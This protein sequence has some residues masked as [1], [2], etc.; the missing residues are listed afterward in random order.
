MLRAGLDVDDRQLALVAA[1]HSG[2]A[3]HVEIARSILQRAGL[4]ESDLG[5]VPA[6]PLD[7]LA[8]A[9]LL[10]GGGHADRVH[11]NCSGKHAG[12][13]ATC[14]VRGWSTDGYLEPS[15]PVQV[16]IRDAVEDLAREPVTTTGVDGCGAPLFALTL[17]GLTRAF[18]AL[19]TASDAT[20]EHRVANA[21]RTHPDVVGGPARVVTRLM[22]GVPG[23][24]AKDGAEGAFAA[25]LPDGRAAAVKI[26]DGASRAAG[27]VLVA[28]LRAIGCHDD[29]LDALATTPVLGGGRPVGHVR[30]AADLCEGRHTDAR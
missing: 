19:A 14:V 10:A 1:S 5:N 28:A 15:H 6:L 23:L 27:P 20:A 29:V 9:E 22:L 13:L 3:M 11:Q 2:T 16:A 24:V 25:A 8:M 17:P 18:A 4:T 7:E 30:A 26:A 12:M 21:M